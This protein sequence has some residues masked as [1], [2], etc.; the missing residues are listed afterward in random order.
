[1]PLINTIDS[2]SA[3]GKTEE[4]YQHFIEKFGF[5]PNAFQ[6]TS[7]SEFLLQQQTNNIMYFM[8]H[9]TL[10]FTLQAFIRMLV[11]TKH[12]CAYCIDMNTGMLLQAGFTIEQIEAAKANPENAPL[13]EKDKA[14]LLY[15]LKVVQN[16][17][18]IDSNDL[19]KLRDMG[20]SDKDILEGTHCGT[21]QI[22]TDMIFNAFK[23]EGDPR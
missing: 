12:E 16:S 23:V 18:S 22:A 10:S 8:S 7:S 19:N 3:T 2:K 14:M 15:I 11:S 21:N 13:P 5:V 9:Q 20:W 1:M 17:N 6:L 4:I